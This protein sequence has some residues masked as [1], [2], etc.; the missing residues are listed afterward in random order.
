MTD[1]SQSDPAQSIPSVKDSDEHQQGRTGPGASQVL[2]SPRWYDGITWSPEVLAAFVS[3]SSF[4]I[5]IVILHHYDGVSATTW[6]FGALTLNSLVAVLATATRAALLALLSSAL[7]QG[8]WLWYTGKDKKRRLR[9]I[10]VFDQASRGPL[11]SLG[12]L[13][14]LRGI[15][16]ATFG[17]IMT[18]LT[19][20]FDIFSQQVLATKTRSVTVHPTSA[21]GLANIPR[22]ELFTGDTESKVDAALMGPGLSMVSA[23]YAGLLA[24]NATEI[25]PTCPTG[26]CTWPIVSSLA[27]CGRCTNVTADVTYTQDYDTAKSM[28]RN[29]TLPDGMRLANH[30]NSD[31][32]VSQMALLQAS[33]ANESYPNLKYPS[34]AQDPQNGYLMLAHFET[35]SLTDPGYGDWTGNQSLATE[36]ALWFCVRAYNISM[37]NG[38]LTQRIVGEWSQVN[39]GA[40]REY[41]APGNST[42]AADG[43]D[44]MLRFTQPPAEFNV[45]EGT[46]FVVGG[47]VAN[48]FST[49]ASRSFPMQVWG[50]NA[51]HA[52][53]NQSAALWNYIGRMDAYIGNFAAILTQT[54]RTS[55]PTSPFTDTYYLGTAWKDEVYVQVRWA[56][57]AFPATMILGGCVVILATVWRT[58]RSVVG[59]WRSNSLALLLTQVSTRVQNAA[60]GAMGVE[61]EDLDLRVGDERVALAEVDGKWHFN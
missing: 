24:F 19:L 6:P 54:L 33:W 20:P 25:R 59:V 28:W 34:L 23:W 47:S 46:N 2:K 45:P 44:V 60:T 55:S 12:F 43:S 31:E 9:D 10:D 3:L 36:C 18:I 30:L 17:A 14:N 32:D 53:T 7:S 1:S 56:W 35:I 4:S 11:G 52:K 37:T 42:S 51:D 39:P 21:A 49:L 50:V 22:A 13:W 61:T 5:L 38:Q 58:D 27:V 48:V 41:T 57:L 29:Y 15:H 8:K 26:N 16:L 40:A